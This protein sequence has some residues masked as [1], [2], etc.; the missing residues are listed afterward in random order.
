MAKVLTKGDQGVELVIYTPTDIP[1]TATARLEVTKPSGATANWSL[2]IADS[3]D[4]RYASMLTYTV[5]SGD[6]DESGDYVLEVY[7]DM[8]TFK[9][10]AISPLVLHVREPGDATV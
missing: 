10:R 7:V 2:T 5:Q 8:G 4:S 9:G 6:L 3:D 1:D